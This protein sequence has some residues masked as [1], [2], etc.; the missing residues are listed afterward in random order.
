M[1]SVVLVFSICVA[2]ASHAAVVSD[3]SIAGDTVNTFEGLSTGSVTGTISQPGATYG[4]AFAGQTVSTATFDTLFGLPSAPLTLT[5]APVANNN[6]GVLNLNGTNVIYGDVN[7]GRGEGALS[8]LFDVGTDIFGFDVV[9]SNAGSLTVEV[10]GEDGSVLG[11][12]TQTATNSFFG[13]RS[14][15]MDIFGV[16]ITNDD[17]FGLGYDNVIFNTSVAPIPLPA[18]LPLLLAGLGSLTLLRR[19]S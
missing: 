14:S 2:G 8:I 16:S 6:I 18:A 1:R 12:I 19:K 13:F 11:N 5:T 7:G 3:N 4:E 17:S 10:F 15:E 9:G